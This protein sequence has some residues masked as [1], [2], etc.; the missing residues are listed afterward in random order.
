MNMPPG[1]PLALCAHAFAASSLTG[2]T[3]RL[4]QG[5]RP[6]NGRRKPAHA[7]FEDAPNSGGNGGGCVEVAT[8]AKAPIAVRDPKDPNGP[9][10]VFVPSAW[11]SFIHRMRSATPDL[12]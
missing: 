12:G 10:L 5:A 6:E 4:P 7:D 3:R 9:K 1:R 2:R 8:T 11:E